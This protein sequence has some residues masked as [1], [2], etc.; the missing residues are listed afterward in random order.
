MR[1][2]RDIQREIDVNLK[3]VSAQIGRGVA[4]GA[5]AAVF[6]DRKL[7]DLMGEALD[8]MGRAM[9]ASA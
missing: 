5:Q 4:A 6:L 2:L 9:A 1:V 3:Q 8:M 7:N